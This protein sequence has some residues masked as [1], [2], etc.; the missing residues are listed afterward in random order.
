MKAVSVDF[1]QG[2]GGDFGG[3]VVGANR[4]AAT[5]APYQSQVPR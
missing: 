2:A 5:V 1:K 3:A 4:N